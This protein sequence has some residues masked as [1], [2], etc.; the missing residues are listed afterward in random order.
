MNKRTWQLAPRGGLPAAT[1]AVG[2]E[3][4]G[5]CGVEIGQFEIAVDDQR[6]EASRWQRTIADL[7]A[8]IAVLDTPTEVWQIVT[9]GRRRDARLRVAWLA[10]ARDRSVHEAVAMARSG[11][12]IL[13]GVIASCAPYMHARPVATGNVLL[14]LLRASVLPAVS[15]RRRRWPIAQI[16]VAGV[17]VSSPGGV[18][19]PWPIEPARWA[20]LAEALA[21][22]PGAALVLR[23]RT[24]GSAP[25]SA[26]AAAER[27]VLDLSRARERVLG[28]RVGET[29]LLAGH[30]TIAAV[31]AARVAAM[32]GPCIAADVSIASTGTIAPHLL[33]IARSALVSG[34]SHVTL[35]AIPLGPGDLLTPLDPVACP[36]LL[37]STREA[38]ALLR[39][40]EPPV[41]EA[42]PLPA[43]RARHFLLA[44]PAPVCAATPLGVGITRAGTTP[45][46]LSEQAR[47]RH[48]YVVGQTG[49]GKS[50]L[51]LNMIVDDIRRGHG[52]TV[53][54]PHG[55][56]VAEVLDR[57]PKERA[58]HVVLVDPADPERCTPLNPLSLAI[59][60]PAA[61]VSFRD[62]V[63]DDLLDTID[64]IYSLRATGGPMF[65]QCFRAFMALLMGGRR[66]TAFTPTLPLLGVLMSDTAL[67]RRLETSLK[68]D[69]PITVATL[70]QLR[71]ATGESA[72]T[73]MLPYVTSKTN[74]FHAH[75]A[76]RRM[77]CQP[78]CL[79]F[80]AILRDRKILLLPLRPAL[81][82]SEAAALVARVI[83]LRLAVAAMSR[84]TTATV[85]PHYLY[86]DEFHTFATERF[87][88]LLSEARKF[89]LGLVLA[90]QYTS[91]LEQRGGHVLDAVLGNVGTT[92]AFRVG[93]RDA[94]LLER[95][96]APRVR[97][98]DI[99]AQPDYHAIVKSAGALGDAPFTLQTR[100]AP[101][102]RI[103]LADPIRRLARL[104]HGRDRDIVDAEFAQTL[105]QFRSLSVV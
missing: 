97:G 10:I 61:Y 22:T 79:D 60:E 30:D 27:D 90:H 47:L 101:N 89:Q 48:V 75:A 105:V 95:T 72:L 70:D 67:Q 15:L 54:D 52:V 104:L 84:S 56:L 62:R 19:P 74:R 59:E 40:F 6:E 26:I 103:G 4:V 9:S 87:A 71:R 77:L 12:G 35:D 43:T 7:A 13:Q 18:L 96:F 42:S 86:A 31:A 64:G 24:T 34:G 45:I 85:P 3:L 25:S 16:G 5:A 98:I 39:T 11:A 99:A 1:L 91:Q 93:A 44:A 73:S 76:A 2:A 8:A 57:V 63:I 94:V 32:R 78:G 14:A 49:T 55:T 21:S 81:I 88:T 80:D 28:G 17:D 23:A 46:G 100:G 53:L 82:G 68:S 29:A 50:T 33:A 102:H 36:D 65:E 83:V 58:D 51:L 20:P 38:S 41:D 92:I 66:P 37:A 69:D